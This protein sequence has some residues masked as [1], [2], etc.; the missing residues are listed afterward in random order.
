[1]C[2]CVCV[3]DLRQTTVEQPEVK[4]CVC[5]QDLRLTTVE[6]PEVEVFTK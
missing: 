6:Q 3:Q 4:V 5:V 1:M 2:V